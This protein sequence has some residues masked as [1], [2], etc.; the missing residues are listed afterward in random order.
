MVN[1]IFS[2]IITTIKKTFSFSGR[3]SRKEFVIFN[4]FYFITIFIVY[5]TE[6]IYAI[7]NDITL[8]VFLTL[9]Y[10]C[11]LIFTIPPLFSLIVRRLH[12]LNA[13]AWWLLITFI[14]FGAL[15]FFA[16]PFKK[17]SSGINKYGEPPT[18]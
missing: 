2:I 4:L 10:F 1:N 5:S 6:E 18:Y 7:S 12:D 13:S 11:V 17:G 15:L 16:L 8:I 3:A 14:P 9:F